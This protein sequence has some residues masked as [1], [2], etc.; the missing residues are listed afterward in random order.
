MNIPRGVRSFPS[1][2]FLPTDHQCALH[3]SPPISKECNNNVQQLF[4]LVCSSSSSRFAQGRENGQPSREEVKELVFFFLFLY[5][6]LA[7]VL[8]RRLMNSRT[9]ESF[10]ILSSFSLVF[11]LL[12]PFFSYRIQ[13]NYR[14]LV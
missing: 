14:P 8:D 13:V 3:A 5:F 1:E 10:R 11:F 4:F 9:N 2:N 7:A 6:C 12:L